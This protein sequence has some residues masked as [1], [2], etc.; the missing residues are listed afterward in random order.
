MVPI[1]E[2]R[3]DRWAVATLAAAFI[4]LAA[5]LAAIARQSA[6]S[7]EAG[8]QVKRAS[9]VISTINL[10]DAYL[11]RS[12]TAIRGWLIVPD[13]RRLANFHQYADQVLPTLETLQQ[14][15]NGNPFQQRRLAGLKPL[16]LLELT[17][18]EAVADRAEKGNRT[19]ALALFRTT[20]DRYSV[21]EIRN[22][23]DAMRAEESRLLSAR[24]ASERDVLNSL[25]WVLGVTG[26]LLA[27]VA[28]GTFVL[29]RRYTHDILASRAR[30]HL[31]NTNLE[32]AVAERTTDL[33]RANDEIQRFAYIVSHD[34]R[35]PL[36][37]IMGFTSELE[38]ANSVL[39][40]FVAEL[41][42]RDDLTVDEEVRQ[43]ACEELPE[44]IGFIRSSTQKMDRLINAILA[45]SRQG[46]RVLSPVQLPMAEVA[47]DIAASL[48]AQLDNQGASLIVDSGLP[49]LFHDRLAI[50]QIFSN[51]LDNAV[52]YL[53]PGRHGQIHFRGNQSGKR[54]IFEVEDNGR[55]IAPE[56]HRRVFELFRRA[57]RQDQQGEG[58]GLAHVNSLVMRLGGKIDLRS[59]VGQGTTFIVELPVKYQDAGDQQ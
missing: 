58:I 50:E 45:L 3:F 14:Q 28:I 51:I 26:A 23:T 15:T 1:N 47:S 6:V 34:L 17:M 4:L 29:V 38:R 5:A 43:I 2:R 31:L 16:I 27:L 57:G 32:G 49:T 46:R 24:R 52:K 8:N 22:Q 37:N 25:F 13:K 56:D 20:A 53:E 12:E 36:V 41:D 30:L 35:S 48:E 39:A 54:A 10:L 55:G 11:E 9:E 7:E 40:G 18:L 21:S 42:K 19:G 59:Q 33:V 44:S